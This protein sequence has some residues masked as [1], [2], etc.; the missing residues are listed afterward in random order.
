MQKFSDG[1]V[2]I[3]FNS[4]SSKLLL[5]AIAESDIKWCRA[6]LES[7]VDDSWDSKADNSS[8]ID[9]IEHMVEALDNFPSN[10]LTFDPP[11]EKW[12]DV[13]IYNTEIS[14]YLSVLSR[15]NLLLEMKLLNFDQSIQDSCID[16][17][18]FNSNLALDI[19][20]TESI[21]MELDNNMTSITPLSVLDIPTVIGPSSCG[22]S[23]TMNGTPIQSAVYKPGSSVNDVQKELYNYIYNKAGTLSLELFC[24]LCYD[25]TDPVTQQPTQIPSN[26]LPIDQLPMSP[27]DDHQPD[28]QRNKCDNYVFGDIRFGFEKDCIDYETASDE[29]NGFSVD[30]ELSISRKVILKNTSRSLL[31]LREVFLKYGALIGLDKSIGGRVQF[32]IQQIN[33]QSTIND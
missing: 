31:H 24:Y 14:L 29:A 10:V 7:I 11:F 33:R 20:K 12:F 16:L 9:K 17:T 21:N 5:L 13:V 32:A 26:T 23:P 30:E 25:D 27:I 28:F 4:G 18:N 8:L 15:L 1:Q 22:L 2:M 6:F 3:D 19:S